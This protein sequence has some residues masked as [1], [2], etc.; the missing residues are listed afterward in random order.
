MIFD[1]LTIF[2]I[3]AV[4]GLGLFFIFKPPQIGQPNRRSRIGAI[5][6]TIVALLIYQSLPKP[7]EEPGL[8]YKI[9]EMLWV[10]FGVLSFALTF[11]MFVVTNF[12]AKKNIQR[13][14]QGCLTL[15]F[16]A[17][18]P[19]L[20]H[21]NTIEKTALRNMLFGVMFASFLIFM[22]CGIAARMKLV[23]MKE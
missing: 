12:Q 17:G 18:G 14:L 13:L 22:G 7:L 11:A 20:I 19:L 1:H 8:Q 5:V 9:Y 16:V 4:G 6:G 3:V 23:K 21:Q 2:Y 15:I 10:S